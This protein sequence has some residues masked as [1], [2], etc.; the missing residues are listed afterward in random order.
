MINQDI[1]ITIGITAYNCHKY[2]KDAIN[3]VINQSSDKWLGI[4]VLDGGSDK[5]TT[6][7]YNEFKHPKFEKYKFEK[8][9]GPY[10]TRTKAIILSKT[11]WYYQLDGDDLLPPNAIE[12]VIDIIEKTPNAEFVYG[13]CKHFDEKKS[14]IKK[15][16]DNPEVLC[17]TTPFNGQSPI[18]KSLYTK[19]GGYTSKL[20][21]NA[22]WDFWISA[23]EFGIKGVGIDNVIYSRRIRP[24]NIGSVYAHDK[25]KNVEI[26]IKRHPQ[27]FHNVY[28]KNLARFKVNEFLA[29]YFKSMSNRRQAYVYALKALEYGEKTHSINEILKENNMNIV[30]YFIRQIAK[31]R[32]IVNIL[33]LMKENP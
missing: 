8:N 24:N 21:H 11:E 32:Y 27:Y 29:R 25:P 12:D 15:S 7:I 9:K 17:Y 26:V 4:L 13:N 31:N 22:D 23:Y 6:K 19:I 33:S 3:S 30:R 28:R 14:F 20:Y 16:I 18:K 1:K 5:K 2:L 10:G